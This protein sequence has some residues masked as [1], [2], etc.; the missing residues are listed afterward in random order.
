MPQVFQNVQLNEVVKKIPV[1]EGSDGRSYILLEDIRDAFFH[2]GDKLFP[3]RIASYP[4]ELLDVVPD[5]QVASQE[6]GAPLPFQTGTDQ[7]SLRLR[8]G[9]PLF[10]GLNEQSE[11]T[12]QS[13][14]AII[15]ALNNLQSQLDKL[16]QSVQMSDAKLSEL[17]MLEKNNTGLQRQ[18][19]S[20][21]DILLA[22]TE[23]VLA[24]TFELHEYTLPRLFIVLPE[25]AYQGLNPSLII[26][27]YANVKFRLYFLCECGTHTTP[28]GP[29]NLNHIHIARHEGYEI[30]RPKEFFRKYGPHILRLLHAL[31]LGI[32]LASGAIPA[33]STISAVDLP[34]H[35]T[36][37]LEQKVAVSIQYLTAYQRT[38]DYNVPG[39]D[40]GGSLAS[41]DNTR[42]LTKMDSIKSMHDHLDDVVQI[43]GADLRRL[44][45]FLER[46][47]QDRALGNLFRT[48]D[49]NGHVKWI[50]LDH[51]RSTY[52]QRQDHAFE[53]EIVLNRG[54]FDKR[55]GIVT[56]VLSSSESIGSFMA[57][58]SRAGAFN[59]LDVHLRHYV[60][61]DLRTLGD[62]LNKT[63]VAKLTLTCH[64]YREVA[65][66]G[67]RKLPAVLKIMVSGKVR[68][69][70]FKHIKDL[71]PG[72]GV[73]IPKELP[74]VRSLELTGIS[75][76]EG[77]EVLE[78]ILHACK[79][80]AV[81]R[82]KDVSLKLNRL[83]SI[84]NGLSDCWNLNTLAIHNCRIPSDG[85]EY[86]A[87]LLRKLEFIRELD[88]GENLIE[89]LGCCEIIEAAGDKLQKLSL[90]YAGFGDEAAMALE[91]VVSG[92]QLRCL[93]VS[94]SKDELGLDATESIIRLMRR[95]HC[96]EL[97]FPRIQE[98]SD[99]L[100]ARMVRELDLSKLE[101]LVIMGS[102]CGDQTAETLARVISNPAYP[103]PTLTKLKIELP[104]GTLAGAQA[105]GAA[106]RADFQIAMVS[107]S[108]SL[109][110]QQ[111]VSNP[112]LLKDLFTSACSRLTIL[113]LKDTGMSDEVASLLCEALKASD[114]VCRLE[115]LDLAENKLTPTG[116]AMVLDS[117]QQ[118]PTLRTLRME[119]H[120]FGKLGSMG[121]AVQGFLETNRTLCRLSISHVNLRELTLGLSGNANTLRA[122]E[123]QYVDGKVD[124][125]FTFGDFLQS[126]Q[127][128]LLRLVI[129][130]AR[131][132]D[133][134]R[135]LEY[136]SQRLKQNYT[137]VDLE[138]S[139]DQGYEGDSYI[140]QRHL[141][142]NREAWRKNVGAKAQDLISAGM[143]PWTTRAICRGA[144]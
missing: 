24:Q 140:L 76:K 144:E 78:A 29:H 35:L 89:D 119:S 93:D 128:T 116:G 34:D 143:D 21:M 46:K 43:E 39:M 49:G 28:S 33:L 69:F 121:M 142:R 3:T 133:D 11:E 38:L 73:N 98:P 96:I 42:Q 68:Y 18:I 127:N 75:L 54:D 99:E 97:V 71:I 136:L 82:L 90:P 5:H 107:F 1:R 65:S 91:R 9:E 124:D 23:A 62:S 12:S 81:F 72:R 32:K 25:V 59:E 118:H 22:K 122:I 7:Q 94:D 135:S 95:L 50:C 85:V 58:M 67:K 84:T 139:Y 14:K 60:F 83:V 108:G 36:D 19:L 88:L 16:Q 125:I 63:N 123:V 111:G 55:F 30:T 115:Y 87:A 41:D 101:S 10:V 100:C 4:G 112:M 13:G 61:Q 104:R 110:F 113:K 48:V 126:S 66:M 74:M 52:H 2:F 44:A 129:K 64:E 17:V 117:L 109:L 132:C 131:V 8:G 15:N 102:G 6:L 114:P 45:S 40:N 31:K 86:I 47:D 77:H 134:D 37:N 105:L 70:H 27:R 92:K 26:S 141:D 130:H 138:W 53:N 57:A 79:N 106:L 20:K 51:Y 56:V 103:P 80:L 137:L 120:S